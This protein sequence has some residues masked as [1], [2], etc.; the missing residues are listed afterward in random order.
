MAALLETG[1]SPM[2]LIMEYAGDAPATVAGFTHALLRSGYAP[3]ELVSRGAV[4]AICSTMAH[5]PD[6]NTIQVQVVTFFKANH[7]AKV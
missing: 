2:H 6:N 7:N 4:G 5:N 1:I 3:H